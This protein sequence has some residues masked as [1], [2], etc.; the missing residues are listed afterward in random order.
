MHEAEL[1]SEY[2]DYL[3]IE[4]IRPGVNGLSTDHRQ[5]N[6]A[7]YLGN[8]TQIINDGTIDQLLTKID[9]FLF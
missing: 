9:N 3:V 5:A 8:I 1:I 7:E 6:I 4:L 2:C